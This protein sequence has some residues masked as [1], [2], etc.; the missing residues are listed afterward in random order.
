M[1]VQMIMQILAEELP[2]EL[3]KR[4]GNRICN[5]TPKMQVNRAVSQIANIY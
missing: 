4:V 2:S 1:Q 3:M 5:E